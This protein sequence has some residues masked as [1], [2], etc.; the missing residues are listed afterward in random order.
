MHGLP[1]QSKEEAKKLKD[2][3]KAGVDFREFL[4]NSVLR[5]PQNKLYSNSAKTQMLGLYQMD[6]KINVL[7]QTPQM[8]AKTTGVNSRERIDP[9]FAEVEEKLS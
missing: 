5:S 8:L 7:Q 9:V 4:P 1:K 3:Y 6:K 2:K